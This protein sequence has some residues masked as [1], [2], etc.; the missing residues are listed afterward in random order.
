MR[1]TAQTFSR[2]A[3]R[4]TPA[5]FATRAAQ[6]PRAMPASR[7]IRRAASSPRRHACAADAS[8]FCRASATAAT[9]ACADAAPR[10]R[11]LVA[12]M[13]DRRDRCE[14]S[15]V[16]CRDRRAAIVSTLGA[17]PRAR[18]DRV[19][20]R[21]APPPLPKFRRDSCLRGA[22]VPQ[23]PRAA[24]VHRRTQR[25]GRCSS[26]RSSRGSLR[27]ACA[28]RRSARRRARRRPAPPDRPSPQTKTGRTRRPVGLSRRGGAAQWPSSSSSSA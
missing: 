6:R 4:A 2:R 19:A 3:T 23:H 21:P 11:R 28:T 18:V 27:A 17:D 24:A 10:Q 8:A 26:G 15:T 20:R 25:A 7:S 16:S 22:V 1:K 12:A 14:C 9:Y 5:R 13:A